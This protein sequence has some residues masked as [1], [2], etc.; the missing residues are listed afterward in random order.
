MVVHR[1]CFRLS[2]E[3]DEGFEY[4]T[5][6]ETKLTSSHTFYS[7][8]LIIICPYPIFMRRLQ[9]LIIDSAWD[10]GVG[11]FGSI[12]WDVKGKRSQAL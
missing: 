5:R 8:C 1:R 2:F 9:D 11:G 10:I 7:A 3:E 12:Y 6:T 4:E